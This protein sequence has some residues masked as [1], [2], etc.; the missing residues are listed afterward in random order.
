MLLQDH[1]P[2]HFGANESSLY[3]EDLQL[4]HRTHEK[5]ELGRSIEQ[6]SSLFLMALYLL[7]M[8]TKS[9][10]LLNHSDSASAKIANFATS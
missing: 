2:N 6:I 4:H 3:P 8:S 5:C 7:D 10:D 1:Q 9:V